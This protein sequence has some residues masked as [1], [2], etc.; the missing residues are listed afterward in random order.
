[1]C[2][3]ASEHVGA[4]ADRALPGAAA[5]ELVH[6]FSLVHDDVQDAS[7]LRRHRPTVWSMWGVGQAVNVG[8]GL[9]ALAQLA[10]L[11][12][13]GIDPRVRLS[14]ARVLN[15]ACVALCRGQGIDLALPD[16][17]ELGL[18][19]YLTMIAGKAGALF[20]AAAELG[21]LL[22]G[23]PPDV[24]RRLG[25]F[26]QTLG[27]VYQMQDDV[28]GVWGDPR[29]TGKLPT[30]VVQRKHGL[31]ATIAGLRASAPDGIRLRQLYAAGGPMAAPDAAWVLDLFDALDVRAEAERL[32]E[33]RLARVARLLRD[34]GPAAHPATSLPALVDAV[35]RRSR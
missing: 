11:D 18:R 16:G 32:T 3:L 6:N 10:L 23:A 9:F 21:A 17:E 1:L 31:P 30:D 35:A 15:R 25:R 7:P 14:A 22:G 33:G 27:E 19:G 12:L 28:A 26:G 29:R 13:G 34:T 4:P 24:V 5:V 2:F 20:G 8:D